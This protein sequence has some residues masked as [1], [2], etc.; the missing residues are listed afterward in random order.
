MSN[1]KDQLQNLTDFIRG[2]A[3]SLEAANKLL[4]VEADQKIKYQNEYND[5][6]N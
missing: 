1:A 5:Q 3:E 4:K 6:L 2:K